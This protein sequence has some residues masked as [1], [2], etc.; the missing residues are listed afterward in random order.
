MS[1]KPIV[2]ESLT[3]AQRLGAT[4]GAMARGD[5]VEENRLKD[6]CPK[7]NYKQ[8]DYHYSGTIQGLMSQAIAH[9]LDLTSITL[10]LM[11]SIQFKEDRLVEKSVQHL[12][13]SV[14]AWHKQLEDM[15][16]EPEAMEKVTEDMRH[17]V[18]KHTLEW[19]KEYDFDADATSVAERLNG[20]K[21]FFEKFLDV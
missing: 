9:E 6:T 12:I 14:T 4:I 18:V 5:A 15:N 17:P 2:Y 13:N 11:T 20:Y 8:A 3:P 16:I 1:I 19:I 7:K 10:T 21:S